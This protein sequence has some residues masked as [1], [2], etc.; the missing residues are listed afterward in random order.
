MVVPDRQRRTLGGPSPPPAQQPQAVEAALVRNEVT[1]RPRLR[2]TTRD[3]EVPVITGEYEDDNKPSKCC[4]VMKVFRAVIRKG[5]QYGPSLLIY[6]IYEDT[7]FVTADIL[8]KA[9]MYN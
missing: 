2:D 7:L 5:G 8:S 4:R 6:R 1:R 9:E 3:L